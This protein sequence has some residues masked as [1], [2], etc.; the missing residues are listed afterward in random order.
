MKN[1]AEAKEKVEMEVQRR[2]SD[3]DRLLA[4][5]YEARSIRITDIEARRMPLQ[6]GEK[7]FRV[8]GY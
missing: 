3:I 7:G 6:L 5:L 1:Q 8:T 2:D 4:R